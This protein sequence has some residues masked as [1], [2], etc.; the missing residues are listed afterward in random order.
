MNM[1]GKNKNLNFMSSILEFKM[2]VVVG[3][4]ESIDK[5]DINDLIFKKLSFGLLTLSKT[6]KF[7]LITTKLCCVNRILP[8]L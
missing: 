7:G 3:V 4:L 8:I 5:F 1:K 2:I 6:P